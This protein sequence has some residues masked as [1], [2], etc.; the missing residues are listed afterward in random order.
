MFVSSG[1]GRKQTPRS[2]V[3]SLHCQ[4][5]TS[6]SRNKHDING[7]DSSIIPLFIEIQ[8]D[9]SVVFLAGVLTLLLYF[10]YSTGF[11]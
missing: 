10:Y 5:E 8:I 11:F 6:K 2:M 1:F 3:L 4:T 7:L 9:A